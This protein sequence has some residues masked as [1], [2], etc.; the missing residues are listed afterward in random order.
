MRRSWWIGMLVWLGVVVVASASAWAV[1]DTAGRQV[2]ADSAPDT[3]VP[4]TPATPASVPLSQAP[5][6]VLSPRP[7]HSADGRA[8]ESPRPQRPTTPSPEQP[9]GTPGGPSSPDEPRTDT[10]HVT[11]GTWRGAVGTV[12]A[13][14]DGAAVRL[15]SASPAD[16]YQVELGAT[17]PEELEV[18][19]SGE[20]GEVRVDASCG[21]GEPRF[22]VESDVEDD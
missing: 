7:S 4:A 22:D 5:A 16:G 20:H 19:F 6:E 12:I 1:I 11:T 14:C 17:G 3:L 10:E 13:R 18:K 2:L 8:T 9:T 15:Y 21:S